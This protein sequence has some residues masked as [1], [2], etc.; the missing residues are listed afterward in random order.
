[1][2]NADC[3]FLVRVKISD[4][5]VRSGPGTENKRIQYCPKGTYTIVEVKAGTGSKKGWGRLKSGLGW[6]SLDYVDRI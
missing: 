5:N 1:M 6:L 4:L 3:P 2:S